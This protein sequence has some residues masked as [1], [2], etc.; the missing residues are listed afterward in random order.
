MV[1]LARQLV[2]RISA[3]DKWV[4]GTG[5]TENTYGQTKRARRYHPVVPEELARLKLQATVETV[6]TC[7]RCG[8]ERLVPAHLVVALQREDTWSALR[9][10]LSGSCGS[11][12][13]QVTA[14][15]AAVLV[16]V[17]ATEGRL[18]CLLLPVRGMPSVADIEEGRRFLG[19]HQ[20]PPE[21]VAG[22]VPS[23]WPAADA[24]L[25]SSVLSTLEA[26]PSIASQ[27][28]RYERRRRVM[29]ALLNLGL[30][31]SAGQIRET[32]RACPELV[33]DGVDVERELL[34]TMEWPP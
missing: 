8:A 14:A 20:V 24:D 6:W 27:L 25:D 11:C 15:Y 28:A 30:A 19:E 16:E 21:L 33:T 10:L 17:D 31:T 13:Q 22:L 12:G 32:L 29:T 2:D 3:R 23:G 26:D 9:D 5:R 4:L 1:H 34:S 7:R 18:G